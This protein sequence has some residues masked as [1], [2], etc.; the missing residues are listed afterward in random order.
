[1]YMQLCI[2]SK[3]HRKYIQKCIFCM[4]PQ[5]L[6]ITYI[7]FSIVHNNSCKLN[8]CCNKNN[9]KLTIQSKIYCPCKKYGSIQFHIRCHYLLSS[10]QYR[11]HLC[12]QSS[13]SVCLVQILENIF[14][15]FNHSHNSN[16]FNYFQNILYMIL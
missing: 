9:R 12:T 8:I 13:H 16:M 1:M 11:R 15:I 3:N 4:K 2:H 5:A 7:H 6:F 10:F 14:F